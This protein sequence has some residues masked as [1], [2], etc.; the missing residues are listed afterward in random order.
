MSVGPDGIDLVARYEELRQNT[1]ESNVFGGGGL[2]VLVRQGV[3][4][5][6]DAWL[7]CPISQTSQPSG[8]AVGSSLPEALAS[9]VVV[10]LTEMALGATR[11]EVHA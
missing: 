1:L 3:A 7:T 10:V 6:I 2:A 11:S 5:W 8:V 4:A 9:D